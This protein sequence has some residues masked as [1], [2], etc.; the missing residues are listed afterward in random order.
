MVQSHAQSFIII[1]MPKTTDVECFFEHLSQHTMSKKC[2][3]ISILA[4]IGV[5]SALHLDASVDTG[6]SFSFKKTKRIKIPWNSEAIPMSMLNQFWNDFKLKTNDVSFDE[7]LSYH[8]FLGLKTIKSD[9]RFENFKPFIGLDGPFASLDVPTLFESNPVRKKR[10]KENEG[11]KDSNIDPNTDKNSISF[12]TDQPK[13][14][15]SIQNSTHAS[16]AIKSLRGMF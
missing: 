7:W 3:I 12:V 13:E 1:Q 4:G 16:D 9:D 11:K 8:L 6:F 5:L 2:T 14:K 10:S 15:K